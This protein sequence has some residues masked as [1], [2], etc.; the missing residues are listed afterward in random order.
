VGGDAIEN[1]GQGRNNTTAALPI[2]LFADAG[3]LEEAGVGNTSLRP[4][5]NNTTAEAS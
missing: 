3:R 1:E 2:P 4:D 5:E